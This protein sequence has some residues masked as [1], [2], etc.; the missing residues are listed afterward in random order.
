MRTLEE[1]VNSGKGDDI[2]LAAPGREGLTYD[3]LRAQVAGTV[4]RLN[5]LGVGRNDRVAIVLPNGPE[6]ASAFLAIGAGATTAPLNPSYRGEEFTFYLE[7]LKPGLLVVDE[8]SDSPVIG[9]ARGLGVKVAYLSYVEANPAGTFTL[10]GEAASAG[11]AQ[12]G[13][14][15]PMIWDWYCTRRAPRR[16]QS[17]CRS[18]S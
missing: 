17:W 9:C 7:D 8:A 10:S 3:G 14:P 11:P 18:A 2:A 16:G 1:L 5:E 13:M 6:M 4:A 15:R 12:P